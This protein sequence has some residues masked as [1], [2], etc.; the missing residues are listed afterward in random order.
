MP[1]L[2]AHLPYVR[3]PEL[4][5]Y[6]E[7]SWFFEAVLECYLP[8]LAVL[9]RLHQR[10]VQARLTVSLSPT[11]ILMLADPLLCGRLDRYLGKLERFSGHESQR[12]KG[13]VYEPVVHFYRDRIAWLRDE[14]ESHHGRMLLESFG[15]LEAGG[16]I[17][18][19]TTAATHAYLPIL[20]ADPESVERQI[21]MGLNVFER[22]LGRRPE[23]F[24]LPECGYMEGLDEVLARV[25]VRHTFVDAHAFRNGSHS[26]VDG[27]YAPVVSPAG[28]IF[29]G[30]DELT[31]RQVW[32]SRD[33][34]PADPV[35]RDFYHDAGYELGELELAPFL[36]GGIGRGPTGFKY[37]RVTGPEEQKMPY[38]R[39]MALRRVNEHAEQFVRELA[40][41]LA[42]QPMHGDRTPLVTSLY[43]AELFGHW[44]FEGPDW[45]EKVLELSVEESTG[46][47]TVT[48]SGY[49]NRFP[50]HE[51][52]EPSSGSWGEGGYSEMWLNPANDWIP[53]RL[54]EA[55]RRLAHLNLGE[56]AA[57]KLAWRGCVNE[58][59][60]AQA[61]DWPF[62]LASGAHST[63]ARKRVEDHLKRFI[64]LVRGLETGRWQVSGQMPVKGDWP[65]M[66]S[67]EGEEV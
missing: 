22:H 32:S 58:L 47:Q 2:H 40:G 15:D 67:T 16:M 25:G 53:S 7:E 30:R 27:T 20:A 62:M 41:R 54:L 39:A 45:L 49:L 38:D 60:L 21:T 1:V 29:F 19:M 34:Y 11:L 6:R 17:E 42:G 5:E 43:D 57:L 48:P 10:N 51:I 13:T 35:Y 46:I 56:G 9:D 12:L 28:V 64:D 66:A 63:Y 44:W 61:S 31:S 14:W 36:W 55:G 52:S 23:G 59:M 50:L 18:L 65:F 8:L 3:H 24:W 33:G 26:P 37:R 4:P